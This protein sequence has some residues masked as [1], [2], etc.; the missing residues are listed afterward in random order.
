VA[1]S[2]AVTLRDLATPDGKP[3]LTIV[4][5]PC[6]REGRYSTHRLLETLGDMGLPDVLAQL[7]QDC[8]KHKNVAIHD[9]CRAIFKW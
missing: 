2:G 6:G 1:R 4:C 3:H 5:Q 8:T 9:R 7:T